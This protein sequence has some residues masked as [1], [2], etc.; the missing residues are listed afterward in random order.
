[1]SQAPKLEVVMIAVS[2]LK[3]YPANAR[4]HSKRQIRQ[5]AASI[6]E[7]GWTNPILV[8]EK[9]EILAGHARL[10]AGIFLEMRKVPC[11]RL[12]GLTDAQARALVIADNQLALNAGWDVD[13][14]K[15]EIEKLYA[16]NF[17]LEVLGFASEDLKKLMVHEGKTDPDEIPDLQRTDTITKPG[18]VWTL[19]R[20]RLICGD[21]TQPAIV[22]QLLAGRQPFLM[23]TDP[24]YGIELDSE[25]RDRAGLNNGSRLGSS[26][27]YPAEASYMKRRIAGHTE[28]TISGDTRAD[29][30]AAFE[31]VPSL[32]V[33]YVWHA[34][35]YTREVLNGLERI[36]F[37]HAQQIIWDKG[38][39]ALT[40]THYW[41]AHEPC[42]CAHKEGHEPCWYAR[43]KNA[44]W[45]GKPGET[46]IW[47]AKSP[48]M[49]MAGSDEE[50]IDH[51]TQ[52]PVELME[53]PIV[54]H[55]MPGDEVYEPFGGS[56]TTLM[57]AER[58]DRV[59]LAIELEPKYCDVIVARWQAYTG[60]E[61]ERIPAAV[62]A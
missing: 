7:F 38:L 62:A 35:R 40:R 42:W 1:V 4:T 30:S 50:K 12:L 6:K 56:G 57:A 29:W 37:I 13:I 51:P 3:R 2:A 47:R 23:V 36:G 58:L 52:K 10:E 14:L 22:E 54:N 55:T 11:I 17:D 18:D 46:T 60:K 45:E 19:G 31:L 24:P 8:R 34:S 15:A 44:P 16:D 39:A 61:A 9:N 43:K 32:K 33:V 49:I 59:C 20:H 53:I 26:T 5:I 41:F 27:P 21:C 28:T 25:W 48:K